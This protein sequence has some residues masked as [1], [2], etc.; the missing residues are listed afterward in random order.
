MWLNRLGLP[1]YIILIGIRHN[2]IKICMY[3]YVKYEM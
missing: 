1:K 3:T 2:Y